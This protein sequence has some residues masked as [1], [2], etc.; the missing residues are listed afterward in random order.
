M[1]CLSDSDFAALIDGELSPSQRDVFIEHL[2]SCPACQKELHQILKLHHMLE[3]VL[4]TEPC[5]PVSALERYCQNLL[6]PQERQEVEE[7]LELCDTCEFYIELLR[8]SPGAVE[9][10]QEQEQREYRA[11]ETDRIGREVTGKLVRQLLPGKEK[12]LTH[13]WDTLVDKFCSWRRN[14]WEAL[15]LIASPGQT[16][17]I[18]GFSETDPELAAMI[19]MAGTTLVMVEDL[20]TTK[21]TGKTSEL[22]SLVFQISQ[23]LGAGRELQE[24]LADTLPGLLAELHPEC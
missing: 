22:R 3:E 12:V 11:Y 8:G 20:L 16:A 23:K 15:D 18:L 1:D 24:R 19:V 10:W 7:H 9:A 6:S 21:A 17:G 14:H 4:T 13:I 2:Q 5:P